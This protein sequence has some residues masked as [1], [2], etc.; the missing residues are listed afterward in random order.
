VYPHSR[1]EVLAVAR[2]VGLRVTE[3]RACFLFSP[4]LYRLA[5]L[6]LERAF[7]SLERHVPDSW[8]CRVFWRMTA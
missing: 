3:R 1:R 6:P 5:P 2:S 7:E 8:L 4:Y